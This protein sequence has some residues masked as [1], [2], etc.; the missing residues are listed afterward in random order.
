MVGLALDQA[1]WSSPWRERSVRDKA[2]LA[3]GLLLVAITAAPLPSGLAV[4]V[5]C[6]GL[7]LG[8]IRVGW[9]RLVRISWLPVV[10]IL[11]GVGTVAVSLSWAAGLQ[12]RVTEQSLLQA[13]SLAVR[14]SAAT[15][16]MLVLACS[17]PM[18]D[19]LEGLRRARVPAPLVE[20]AALSYRFTFGLLDSASA[21]QQAQRARLGFDTRSA[22][23][24][25][26]AAGVAAIFLRSWDRARRLEE[27]L[28]GRGYEGSLRT[29]EPT[30]HRSRSFLTWSVLLLV[31]LVAGS[32]LW[33]VLA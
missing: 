23:M 27:G 26:A 10:S 30:R 33:A 17:T 20:I 16:A 13:S 15:L 5:I 2:V 9:V 7:L 18:I 19:L 32:T 3:G 1:A 12:L 22:T 28:S 21:I 14:A 29:L 24:R 6:L 11:V 8:P 4:M 31:A 25:S